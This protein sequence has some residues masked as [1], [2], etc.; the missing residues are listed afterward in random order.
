[1]KIRFSSLLLALLML[2]SLAPALADGDLNGLSTGTVVAGSV[3]VY[4]GTWADASAIGS[5]PYGTP[6]VILQSYGEWMQVHA[7]AM[8]LVGWVSSYDIQIDTSVMPIYL[9]VVISQNVSL[10]E[11]PSTGARRIASIPNGE[12]LSL[13]DEQNG[14][15]TVSWWD[16]KSN[17]P[18]QGYV[19]VDYVVRDPQYITTTGSTYVYST[20]SR[21]SKKVGQV[22]SGT[23]LV[24]IGEWG[25]FWVV[26]LRSASGFIYKRDV[27]DNYLWGGNG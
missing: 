5:L 23:Q 26:N 11:S 14:W 17:T 4:D 25:D 13:L 9:G 16:S 27:E 7:R 21:S 20:P 2:L 19:L 18:Q 10:R 6:V 24:V 1:M 12:M 8:R 3:T 15:Y 22:V